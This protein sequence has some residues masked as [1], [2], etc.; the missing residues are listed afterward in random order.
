MH[1][2]DVSV[3]RVGGESRHVGHL[4][5]GHRELRDGAPGAANRR[6][7]ARERMLRTDLVVPVRTNQQQVAYL[8]MHD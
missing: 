6:D 4:Q 2:V 5:W 1:A 3:Q 8:G 7:G